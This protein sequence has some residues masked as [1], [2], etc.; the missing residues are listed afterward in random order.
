MIEKDRVIA[1]VRDELDGAAHHLD[2]S[3]RV[4][5]NSLLL[6]KEYKDIDMQVLLTSALVHDIG[7][8][9]QDEDLTGKTDHALVGAEKVGVILPKLGFSPDCVEQIMHCVMTHRFRNNNWPPSTLEAQVLFDADKLD[10]TGAIGI[11]RI[12][13]IAGQFGQSL[14]LCMNGNGDYDFSLFAPLV[15]YEMKIKRLIERLYTEKGKQLAED[16]VAFM[17]TFFHEYVSE[18]T[19]NR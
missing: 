2:H 6:A 12:F 9:E 11:A 14:T 1:A 10:L 4:Y 13:M 18:I 17:R 7:R 8:K 5:Q 3:L 19:D 16:R 15:Q